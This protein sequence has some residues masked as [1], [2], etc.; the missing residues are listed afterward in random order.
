MP[1]WREEFLV[2]PVN[3]YVFTTAIWEQRLTRCESVRFVCPCLYVCVHLGWGWGGVGFP[4]TVFA[5][6]DIK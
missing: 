2:C 3:A 1:V 4:I 6:P 5:D